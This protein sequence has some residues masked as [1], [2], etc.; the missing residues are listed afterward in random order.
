MQI[1]DHN[2]QLLLRRSPHFHLLHVHARLFG[3]KASLDAKATSCF[4]EMAPL[5]HVSAW[6]CRL[7]VQ[8]VL[9]L[10]ASTWQYLT[11]RRLT[12]IN[13]ALLDQDL[14]A[15]GGYPTKMSFPWADTDTC[16]TGPRAR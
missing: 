1:S 3:Q 16:H 7:A 2:R 9:R 4:F 15:M 13:R 10:P 8:A 6:P 5:Q 11:G 12:A 14:A